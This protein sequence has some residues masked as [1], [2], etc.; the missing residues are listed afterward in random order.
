MNGGEE[1]NG[2]SEK[3]ARQSDQLPTIPEGPNELILP[4]PGRGVNFPRWVYWIFLVAGPAVAFIFNLEQWE[5]FTRKTGMWTSLYEHL[6]P[7]LCILITIWIV[8]SLYKELARPSHL[9]S[10]REGLRLHWFGLN[11]LSSSDFIPWPAVMGLSESTNASSDKQVKPGSI[12]LT[13]DLGALKLRPRSAL[14]LLSPLYFLRSRSFQSYCLRLNPRVLPGNTDPAD[15]LASFCAFIPRERIDP[16]LQLEANNE[17]LSYTRLWLDELR[18]TRGAEARFKP[19]EGG[20][21]V[22]QGKYLIAERLA[23]GGQAITYKAADQQGKPVVLKEFVIPMRGGR[24]V[25]RRA[26]A[27]VDHEVKLLSNL[28]SPNIVKLLDFFVDGY[29]EP[30]SP[31]NTSTVHAAAQAGFGEW[32]SRKAPRN[33]WP[34]R[35]KWLASLPTCTA[36]HHL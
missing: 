32:P 3:P 8:A 26:L 14:L 17:E 4:F 20:E 25:K 15:L 21:T 28:N 29:R 1:T 36:K 22:Y 19:L 35:G 7:F 23:M 5:R 27:S 24:E 30:T 31:S 6:F 18:A 13:I 10:G 16:I 9:Q 12:D 2:S 11:S 34:W 33:C